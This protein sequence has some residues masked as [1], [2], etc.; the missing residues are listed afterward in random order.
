M[1]RALLFVAGDE[2][3]DPTQGDAMNTFNALIS[4]STSVQGLPMRKK[5]VTPGDVGDS[6]F[7]SFLQKSSSGKDGDESGLTLLSWMGLAPEG[8]GQTASGK[9]GEGSDLSSLI[10]GCKGKLMIPDSALSH[11]R[12]FLEKQGLATDEIDQFLRSFSTGGGDI[13]LDRLMTKLSGFLQ[14]ESNVGTSLVVESTDIPRVEDALFKMGLNVEQVNEA[15]ENSLDHKGNLDLDRLADS[16]GKFFTDVGTD[17]GSRLATIFS[18]QLGIPVR[19]ESTEKVAQQAGLDRMIEQITKGSS[20]EDQAVAKKEIAALLREKG[21]QPQEVKQFLETLSVRSMSSRDI[22]GT[23]TLSEDPA[24]R[25]YIRKN[26]G[27]TFRPEWKEQVLD[28]LKQ[29]DGRLGQGNRS[30]GEEGSPSRTL[31]EMM[32][33]WASGSRSSDPSS[34]KANPLL[35]SRA[36]DEKGSAFFIDTAEGEEPQGKTPV[37]RPTVGSEF[38]IP[39]AERV[40]STQPIASV[41]NAPQAA[42]LPEPLPK[43]VDRMVW[44]VRAG[45]QKTSLQIRPPELGRLDLDL[46]IRQGHVSAHL[47]AENPMVKEL[48][49]ANL[50]QLKQQ[51]NN[52]GL[53]VERFEVHAGLDDRRFA[54]GQGRTGGRSGRRGGAKASGLQGNAPAVDAVSTGRSQARSLHQIDVLA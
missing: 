33:E 52:L 18:R 14:Q 16:L 51:L 9:T 34:A 17:T 22:S 50:Q 20:S 47:N 8:E 12:S 1:A 24:A 32:K 45:E 43:V 25:I 53:T 13:R 31:S 11:I 40:K 41:R 2:H 4:L 37:Q 23:A 54:D 3:H 21:L 5:A 6:L 28:I 19:P 42:P 36:S 30:S 27:E 26:Q 46:V 39:G 15:V 48:I 44:M 10:C 49:E 38:S 7:Q 35:S 29:E